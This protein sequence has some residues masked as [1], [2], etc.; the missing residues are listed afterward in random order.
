MSRLERN[1]IGEGAEKCGRG[2]RYVVSVHDDEANMNQLF[3]KGGRACSVQYHFKMGQRLFNNENKCA[4]QNEV[5]GRR[6]HRPEG[7]DKGRRRV[8]KVP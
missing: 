3:K 5:T 4:M 7:Q 6:R 2:V 8:R 1:G